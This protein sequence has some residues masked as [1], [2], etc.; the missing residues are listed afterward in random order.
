MNVKPAMAL[1]HLTN[2]LGVNG[3]LIRRQLART[4]MGMGTRRNLTPA[5]TGCVAVRVH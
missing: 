3:T 2:V 5:I 4:V 1:E